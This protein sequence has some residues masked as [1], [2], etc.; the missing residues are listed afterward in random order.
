MTMLIMSVELLLSEHSCNTGN[1]ELPISFL[2]GVLVLQAP[3]VSDSADG[4]GRWALYREA[5]MKENWQWQ[6]GR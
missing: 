1:R 3:F 2:G 6:G 4:K 5:E